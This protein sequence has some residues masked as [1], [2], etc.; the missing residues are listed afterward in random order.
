M[1]IRMLKYF[2]LTHRWRECYNIIIQSTLKICLLRNKKIQI[3]THSNS[4]FPTNTK[5]LK[6]GLEIKINFTLVS[7]QMLGVITAGILEEFLLA[8]VNSWHGY[9]FCFLG[10]TKTGL[11][12][13]SWLVHFCMLFLVISYGSAPEFRC[14]TVIIQLQFFFSSY[15]LSNFCVF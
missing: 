13:L 14:R 10:P 6:C 5:N 7:V 12:L 9:C 2:M 8:L 4:F 1:W 11:V 15:V 3:K